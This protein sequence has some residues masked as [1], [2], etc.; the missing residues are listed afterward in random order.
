MFEVFVRLYYIRPFSYY[1]FLL[2]L[3]WTRYNANITCQFH[4]LANDLKWV[5]WP[6]RILSAL[7]KPNPICNK[8]HF[9]LHDK[10]N[11]WA[12]LSL[13]IVNWN[14]N[15]TFILNRLWMKRKENILIWKDCSF[16]G[17]FL[18]QKR[19]FLTFDTILCLIF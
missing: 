18:H 4:W 6:S 8:N 10:K 9:L 5:F 3:C 1:M 11:Q 17:P 13:W 15:P 16:L 2:H 14:K 19:V 12:H 7:R